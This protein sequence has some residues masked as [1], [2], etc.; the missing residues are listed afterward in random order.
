[1]KCDKT[2]NTGVSHSNIH[3]IVQGLLFSVTGAPQ[4][5]RF[6]F[7]PSLVKGCAQKHPSKSFVCL[8]TFHIIL[9]FLC[10]PPL[11]LNPRSNKL[12]NVI[13][14]FGIDNAMFHAIVIKKIEILP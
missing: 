13:L 9:G 7:V 4:I 3:D 8:E 12:L 14:K 10:K 5:V 6:Q 1:M 11:S 2:K